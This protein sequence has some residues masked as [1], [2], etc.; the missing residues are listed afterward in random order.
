MG[1]V[2]G[3]IGVPGSTDHNELLV[4]NIPYANE[5]FRTTN[6]QVVSCLFPAWYKTDRDRL[7]SQRDRRDN[8]W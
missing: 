3:V 7:C 5:I 2:P 8:G 4:M 1:S 6:Y